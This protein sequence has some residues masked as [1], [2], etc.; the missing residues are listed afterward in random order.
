MLNR[1]CAAGYYCVLVYTL[2]VGLNKASRP[3]PKNSESKVTMVQELWWVCYVVVCWLVASGTPVGR[4]ERALALW[5]AL[6]ISGRNVGLQQGAGQHS[7]PKIFDAFLR[8]LCVHDV[9]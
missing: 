4:T 5:G 7:G 2:S 6:A 8:A 1:W 9:A 3:H